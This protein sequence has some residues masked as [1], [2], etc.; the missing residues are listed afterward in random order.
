MT[1]T[2]TELRKF[3]APE[4]V[5]GPGSRRLVGRYARNLGATRVLIVSDPGVVSAGWLRE[6]LESLESEGLRYHLFVNVSP[7][8]RAEEV[9]QGVQVYQQERCDAIVAVGGGSPMDCAK[10]IGI[11][12]ANKEHILTFEG[13]DR[14]AKPIPP[15]ICVPT[16]AG[17]SADVSQFAII[18]DTR[19]RLKVSI[20][21]K[22]I[23]P[24]VSLIDYDTTRT[25]T[26]V[27]IACC[28]MDALVHGIEAFVSNAHSILTDVYALA[29][30]SLIWNNLPVALKNPL[31]EAAR[32]QLMD[33]SLEAGLAFSNTSLGAIH[34]MAHAMGG[35]IDNPHGEANTLLVDHVV[36]FNYEA[37]PERFDLIAE[38]L[39]LEPAR[40]A[41]DK[42]KEALVS[43]LRRLKHGMGLDLRLRD[44]GISRS[45]IPFLARHALSDP[46]MATNPRRLTLRDVEVLYEQ[47][48]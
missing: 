4:I 37:A 26:P 11:V 6:V 30:I 42:R 13:V 45:D 12:L 43:A 44:R 27:L 9:H 35:L 17:T 24:D 34:A 41:P 39:G 14:I 25:L 31:D 10:G 7:N 23:V 32:R 5:Y 15:L 19:R 21:S 46:C 33:G 3:V 36:A 16:T 8:P 20:V 2:T 18:T 22:A 38:K 1:T 48:L 28:G 47:A 40:L 29:A